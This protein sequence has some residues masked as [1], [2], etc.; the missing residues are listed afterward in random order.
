VAAVGDIEFV[1]EI[2]RGADTSVYRVRRAGVDYALKTLN[3]PVSA[4]QHGVAAFCREAALLA[5]VDHPGVPKVFDVGLV[6][7][8]PSLVME[9]LDG[10]SLVR[11][12]D[13]PVPDE[14]TL[15]SLAADVAAALAA[16]HRAGLVHRDIKP[17]NIMI[18]DTGRAR[19]ID[20]G[21]VA[22]DRAAP[23]DDVAVGTFAYSAPEQT[24][25]LHR[26]VDGRSDLYALGVVLFEY[27]TGS[28]PYH[29]GDVGELIAMHASAPVPDPRS[30]RP[31]LSDA[32][33]TIIGRL[34]A[35]DPDDRFPTADDLLSALG[36]LPGASPRAVTGPD[37]P[38][39]GLPLVGREKE[40]AALAARWER[41]RRGEGGIVLI[42]GAA[43]GGKSGLAQALAAAA[44][45]AGAL[46]LSCKCDA[47]A[48]LP[49][50]ALRSAVEDH[51][52]A[53]VAS[54]AE[55]R[56]AAVQRLRAAV[57]S[58]AGLLRSLSP[59][60][61]VLLD[62]PTLAHGDRH[63][64][65]TGAVASFLAALAGHPSTAGAMLLLDD[66]QWLDAVSLGVLRRLVEDLA[67]VPLLVVA[68]VR[69]DDA[70]VAAH[71]AF[72]ESAGSALDLRLPI[73]PLS[74]A[75][76]A[77]LVSAY[78]P[79]STVASDVV[80]EL[81]ARG[82][83][84]PFTILEYL[85]SLIDVGALRPSWGTWRLDT[86]RLQQIGLPENV[87]EL[88]L[89]RIDGLSRGTRDV[90]VVAAAI[91]NVVDT[92]LLAEASGL[93]LAGPL[94]E[95]VNR[96][97]LH[98]Q[99]DA[100]AFVHDRIR[101]ALLS[102]VSSADLR[103]LHQRVATLL[104]RRQ[105]AGHV[106]IYAVA[107]H[108]AHGES[109]RTPERVFTTGWQAGQLALTE[110]APDAAVAFLEPA[111]SAAKRAGI[112]P[113]S[114]FREA[115]GIAY[116][117]TGR[118]GPASEH[119]E[120]GLAAET[121]PL[122][123]ASLLL[124][125][126]HVRRIGWELT[127]AV[128]CARDGLVELGAGVPDHPVMF[129]L[130]TARDMLRWL[131]TGSR[132]PA[133]AP[134]QGEAAERL[135]LHVLLCR[136]AVAAAAIDL[137]HAQV[138]EFTLRSE[139]V[140]HRL[141]ANDGYLSH[142]SAIGTIAGSMGLRKRRD[143]IYRRAKDLATALGDP[144]A[145]A[146]AAWSEAF[147]KVLGKEILVQ[148]WA[149]VCDAQRSYLDVDFYTNILL[150]RC[151]DL[152]QRGYATEALAWHDRGRSRISLSAADAFPGFDVLSSMAKAL[153]GHTDAAP[154]V[155]AARS[156]EP[157]DAGHGIQFMLGAVQTALEHDELGESFEQAVDAFD[158]LGLAL[159]AIFTEYRM[160]FV[161]VAFARLT[162]LQR[163]SAGD[164]TDRAAR[165]AAAR[166]AIRA[167]HRAATKTGPAAGPMALGLL[168]GYDI[169][170]QAGLAQLGGRHDDAL[171]VLA[172]GEERLVRL[173][174]PLV[175]FEAARVRARALTALGEDRLGRRQA[176]TALNLATEH[177]WAR[178][179]RWVRTEFDVTSAHRVRHASRHGG[180]AEP[181]VTG[182]PY[183]RRLEALQQV[184]MASAKVLDPHQ[185]ARVA[186][187][188]T[189]R[190]L[191]AERAV[192]L[193]VD[194]NDGSLRP[195]LGRESGNSDLATIDAYSS[196]LVHRVAADRRPL[197]VTGSEEG[198]ALGSQ[199]AVVYGLRS[200]IIAPLELDDRLTGVIYLDSRVAKGVF[201]EAD[202][203][204]LTAVASH[205]AISL[206]TARA[207]QLEVAVRAAQQQRDTAELLRT[208]MSELSST[209][210]PQEV[211]ARLLALTTRALPADRLVVVHLDGDDRC[212]L[213][214]GPATPAHAG[215]G[216]LDACSRAGY[217]DGDTAP[218]EIA[219]VLGAV[220]SWIAAPLDTH[221]HGRGVVLAGAPTAGAFGRSDQDLLSALAG[222]AAAAYENAR[223]FAR[224][225]QLAT[226]DGLTGS[227]NRRHFTA[228]ATTQLE[229]ARRNHRP[230]TAMM[231]D[232]DHFKQVNDTHGH[233]V[234]DQVI[235]AVAAV[236]RQHIRQPDV[237][238]R[239]GGEEFAIVHSEMHGDPMKLGERLRA[240]VEAITVSGPNEP[241]GV[242]VS[243][244]VAELKPDDD[245][246]S[247]LGRADEALYRAKRAGRN[248][249]VA[250]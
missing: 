247:L 176:E 27:A 128:L 199:S 105:R 76:T 31:A 178:R 250:G 26:P 200:I 86:E 237:V 16:V 149:D 137:K 82:R 46:V 245:L 249:V 8:R 113:D 118:I 23:A 30:L 248:Q 203:D 65:F 209:L 156:T 222:Q 165:L 142:L 75:E 231:V 138:V 244:G 44:A 116:W 179:A 91:G 196:T 112:T 147:S 153:M 181:T 212:A 164:A 127:K 146:N 223:L 89:A 228:A 22:V 40:Q 57:G 211:L 70:A 24:G 201:T 6:N 197:V 11:S 243:I 48:P 184:S 110:N 162:Q 195:W 101:E 208:A 3:G 120:A 92:T 232:V 123:R 49:M 168:R 114:R 34:L 100:Y 241:I 218:P 145:Y 239:Y 159:S 107:R 182:N 169:V 173:D 180:A 151:R 77:E 97:L 42:S 74:D 98:P 58:G 141:G 29:A 60:L 214:H 64:Q 68:T 186:L 161:Y 155:L 85:R 66:V 235:K 234:G 63:D 84:N 207:A 217:G 117:S 177:G 13:G 32:F 9:F 150:M 170:A 148:E 226:T 95:A 132:A 80:A 51:V 163:A 38:G 193:L 216:V 71:Q 202:V 36:G 102:A 19:L 133:V 229:I 187:D 1:A 115:I 134:V 143:R 131:I 183:R 2:G 210:A 158:R 205:I 10:Q 93:N 157:L 83:G 166:A 175:Q 104:D 130:A 88:V 73:G 174:A 17:S 122:R 25:M 109:D 5:R 125:L 37:R 172:K 238:G 28:L 225:Q 108:Y 78:L 39:I 111:E 103:A 119:L 52:G 7:G 35:K 79:G 41:A 185:V 230:M 227:F 61:G 135:R 87:L 213:A 236:L 72:E 81:S 140:A 144:K 54:P 233:A 20:F 206:E 12:I 18:S 90:L 204:I 224:V 124:Q 189:L 56:E 139:P 69:D 129:G 53:V 99:G 47:D 4:D 62:A 191:G 152:V 106:D 171:S 160:F 194:E 136:A 50:A 45:A 215:P 43:G 59:T 240:A 190:I 221:G 15:V 14:D 21:L 126:S 96:G 242:T 55:S 246:D 219:A 154:A 188:E 121:D 167:L 94:A 33:A 67:G 220:G 198:A 192:L